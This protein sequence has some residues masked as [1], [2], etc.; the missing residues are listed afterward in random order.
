[1]NSSNRICGNIRRK[2]FPVPDLTKQ[3]FLLSSQLENKTR[4][5]WTK[6]K[7]WGK[8]TED[9]EYPL[10]NKEED[11]TEHVLNCEKMPEHQVII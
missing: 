6:S 2:L 5:D 7:L 3:G 4:H 8:Y 11:T 1:M 9:L 10:S